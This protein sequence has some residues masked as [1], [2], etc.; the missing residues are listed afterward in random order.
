MKNTMTGQNNLRA[1]KAL[2]MVTLS[3]SFTEYDTLARLS[4]RRRTICIS[5]QS[6]DTSPHETDSA[7]VFT[8][9]T[10]L[11]CFTGEGIGGV[12]AEASRVR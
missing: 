5:P 8:L 9:D 10:R 2:V 4:K 12:S 6:Y 11:H 1:R 7:V 3:G